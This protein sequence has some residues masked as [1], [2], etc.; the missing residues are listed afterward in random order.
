MKKKRQ[1][2]QTLHLQE[3]EEEEAEEEEEEEE[4]EEKKK[5]TTTKC[6]RTYFDVQSS[7]TP[8]RSIE[9]ATEL[10]RVCLKQRRNDSANN[11]RTARRCES[12]RERER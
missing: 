6:L 7:F 10:C 5:T 2:T 11:V 1:C 9:E 4:E 12:E 8:R 3:E